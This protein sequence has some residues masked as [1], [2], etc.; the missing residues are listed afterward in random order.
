MKKPVGRRAECN[1][2]MEYRSARFKTQNDQR[3]RNKDHKICKTRNEF[4]KK[5]A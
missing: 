4:K 5:T 3:H 2:K 1:I